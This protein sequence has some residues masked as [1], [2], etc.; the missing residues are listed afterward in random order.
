MMSC[1]S[2]QHQERAPLRGLSFQREKTSVLITKSITNS[3]PQMT[4]KKFKESI[5]L[6]KLIIKLVVHQILIQSFRK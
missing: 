5:N 3:L 6:I 1:H 2:T 4:V